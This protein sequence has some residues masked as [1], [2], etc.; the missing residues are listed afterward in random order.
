MRRPE[1]NPALDT[2]PRTDHAAPAQLRL[3]GGSRLRDRPTQPLL[4]RRRS[5]MAEKP[6]HK[7]KPSPRP[8]SGRPNVDGVMLHL[9]HSDSSKPEDS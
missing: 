7:P 5:Q 1:L 6:T 4:H 3:I 2:S 8:S 9:S